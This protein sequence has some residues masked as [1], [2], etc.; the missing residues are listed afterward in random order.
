MRWTGLVVA[1]LSAALSVDAAAEP[2][3]APPLADSIGAMRE[4][5]PDGTRRAAG[6]VKTGRTYALGVVIG[7][8]TP[9]WPGRSFKI[10]VTPIPPVGRLTGHDDILLTHVG[11]GTQLDGFAHIGIEG[12]HL[13]GARASD[14]FRPDGVTRFGIESVPP[15]A[16]RGVLLDMV[17]HYGRPPP[18]GTAFNRAEIDAAARAAGVRIGRGDVVLFH[19][20]W[21]AAMAA[22]DGRAFVASQPGLGKEGADY[23]AALGVAM[24]G[25]DTAALEAIPFEKAEEPFAVHAALLV[26]HGVHILENVDTNALAA[27]G[28]TEFLFVLGA[29]RLKGTVQAI[30]N[31]VAIR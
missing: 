5:S 4:L 14:F 9:V 1:L 20:G 26:R 2:A 17:K 12:V 8:D 19:T 15:A 22:T 13:G 16:T 10:V 29:P 3:A 30:V 23:L 6:L 11:I 7:P 24:I 21:M 28:A 18:P 25:A 27:D 31:P